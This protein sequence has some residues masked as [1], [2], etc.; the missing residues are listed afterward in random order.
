MF[1]RKI[2]SNKIIVVPAWNKWVVIA[3]GIFFSHYHI[4]IA[5][6]SQPA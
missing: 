2:F 1:G 4:Y 3:L 6:N 5:L